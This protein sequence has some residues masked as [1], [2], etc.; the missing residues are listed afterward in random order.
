VRGLGK[1]GWRAEEKYSIVL[2]E[3]AGVNG[4]RPF[5]PIRRKPL[6]SSESLEFRVIWRVRLLA[7]CFW[8]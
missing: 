5:W 8:S 7:F 6:M 4:R 1:P 3:L 2:A